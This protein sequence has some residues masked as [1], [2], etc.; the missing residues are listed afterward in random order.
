M[1]STYLIERLKKF[2][3][4]SALLK[5]QEASDM[6]PYNG[7]SKLSRGHHEIL[8]FR[9]VKNKY[10]KKDDCKHSIIVELENEIVFLP[11][12]F[13]VAL[14]ESDIEELNTDGQK[15]YLFFGGK[16]DEKE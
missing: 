14:K 3:K 16:R 8:R 13:A 12:Y 15:K 4:M 5:L 1:R 11:K 7:F 9:M 6:K 10:S 2:E